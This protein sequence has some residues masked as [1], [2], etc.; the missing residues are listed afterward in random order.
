M[1]HFGLFAVG[2]VMAAQLC[3]ADAVQAQARRG[4]LIQRIAVEGTNRI[5]PETVGSYLLVK[6]GEPYD[7][8]T[9]KQYMG[10][11]RYQDLEARRKHL[12]QGKFATNLWR[13]PSLKG[14][15][16]EKCGHPSQKPLKL[17]ERIILSS[18]DPGDLILD[19]F[20]GSGTTAVIAERHGRGW[21][22]IET[23]PAYI[24]IAKGRLGGSGQ[25]DLIAI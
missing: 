4:D 14:N 8:A 15:S 23:D 24:E 2:I 21:L 3:A 19:P 25:A 6:V 9:I 20:L 5:D 12:E 13:I 17:I 22:G 16:K 1:R 18:T 11:K 10:D 7:A